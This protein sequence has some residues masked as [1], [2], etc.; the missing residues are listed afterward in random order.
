MIEWIL[1]TDILTLYERDHPVV[2]QHCTAH[3]PASVA[4]TIISVE[5]QFS[6]WYTR[7]RRAKN[8]DELAE[9]YQRFTLFATFISRLSICS[10]AKAA[11][12]RYEELKALKLNIGKRDLRIAAIAL[13][14]GATLVTR[15]TAATSSVCP[16]CA[17]RIG[18]CERSPRMA[19]G[20]PS[21]GWPPAAS[22]SAQRLVAFKSGL[23]Q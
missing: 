7:L 15:V 23:P 17:S 20:E 8:P 2:V 19:I 9:I 13:D 10:F 3:A 6:G 18:Q 5:E 11:I 16:A 21:P 12:L 1:D 14:L 22:V 4:I